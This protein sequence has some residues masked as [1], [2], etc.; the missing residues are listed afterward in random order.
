MES[1]S[2]HISM[3]PSNLPIVGTMA[4]HVFAD[5]IIH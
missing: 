4:T 1:Y 3:M 2:S 5:K